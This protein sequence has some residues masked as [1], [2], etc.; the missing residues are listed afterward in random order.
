M[1]VFMLLFDGKFPV[2]LA[3]YVPFLLTFR[4]HV[5][6]CFI[7]GSCSACFPLFC[8]HTMC[9]LFGSGIMLGDFVFS[10]FFVLNV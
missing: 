9:V 2:M 10:A 1:L 5:H 6:F 7:L 3:K 4:A 8:F